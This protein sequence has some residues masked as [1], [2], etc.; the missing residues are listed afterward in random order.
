MRLRDAEPPTATEEPDEDGPM[1]RLR[2]ARE[3]ALVQHEREEPVD[4]I[5]KAFARSGAGGKM[6]DYRRLVAL[7]CSLLPGD[8]EKQLPEILKD[9]EAGGNG[10]HDAGAGRRR[11][12]CFLSFV[13][14]SLLFS[15]EWAEKEK[16]KPR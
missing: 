16:G 4:T 13:L 3:L 5:V 10:S 14:L 15:A 2:T 8:V 6:G 11:T 7:S 1:D 9:L 12:E